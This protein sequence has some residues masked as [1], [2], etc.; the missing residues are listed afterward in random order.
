MPK[1]KIKWRSITYTLSEIEAPNKDE[2]EKLSRQGN[3]T[4]LEE[5]QDEGSMYMVSI[6][7]IK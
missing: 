5:V 1:Y 3:D 6:E 7:E 4:F 2:A